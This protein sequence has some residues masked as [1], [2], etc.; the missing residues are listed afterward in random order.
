M[1]FD[2]QP[3]IDI[4]FQ[5]REYALSRLEHTPA[6]MIDREAQVGRLLPRHSG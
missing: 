4:D 6:A 3:D 2:K 5:D 1:S